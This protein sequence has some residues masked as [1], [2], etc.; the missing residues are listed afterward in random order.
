MSKVVIQGELGPFGL[1]NL[2]QFLG[3]AR[4]TGALRVTELGLA[5]TIFLDRGNLVSATS[6]DQEPIGVKLLRKGRLT[7]AELE[8][9]LHLQHLAAQRG[10]RLPIG[11]ILVH[12]RMVTDK[13]LEECVFDQIIETI[14]LTLELPQPHFSF[15]TME[16]IRPPVFHALVSFQVALLEAFRVADEVRRRKGQGLERVVLSEVDGLPASVG[17]E[18]LPQPGGGLAGDGEAGQGQLL[19]QAARAAGRRNEA[20]PQDLIHGDQS[21]GRQ[22]FGSLE[23]S[24]PATLAVF[25]RGPLIVGHRAPRQDPPLGHEGGDGLPPGGDGRQVV[26]R[27]EARAH[28]RA[29]R[30]RLPRQWPRRR[31]CR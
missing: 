27:V 26:G 21:G 13:E 29:E 16:S 30:T 11:R 20:G 6:P 9:A 28:R 7:E 25:G 22:G 5:F 8:R 23:D 19:G 18:A 31:G 24:P 17:S 15:A 12:Q 4:L 3:G 2:V 14:C 1:L 10:K